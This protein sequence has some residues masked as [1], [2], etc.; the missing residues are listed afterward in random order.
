MGLIGTHSAEQAPVIDRC[1]STCTRFMPRTRASAW[2]QTPT[3]PPEA[4]ILAPQEIDVLAERRIG[5]H[6]EGAVPELAVQMLG[7][8]HFTPCP[9]PKPMSTGPQAARNAGKVPM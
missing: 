5:R 7:V 9:E 2:R 3:T 6:G 8:V 4:S 1:G